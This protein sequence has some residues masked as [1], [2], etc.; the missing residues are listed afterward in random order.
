MNS[1]FGWGG[2]GGVPRRDPLLE[3]DGM[4]DEEGMGSNRPPPFNPS[5]QGAGRY[6]YDEPRAPYRETYQD[7]S[8]QQQ[9]PARLSPRPEARPSPR[10]SPRQQQQVVYPREGPQ[11]IYI[12]RGG[13]QQQPAVVI[14]RDE[15]RSPVA[16]GVCCALMVFI[17]GFTFPLLWLLAC[18][19]LSSPSRSVRFLSRCSILCLIL[20]TTGLGAIILND[21]KTGK[22]PWDKECFFPWD[23]KCKYPPKV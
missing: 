23:P 20:V 2:G 22:W 10:Q 17:L 8:R 12:D 13:G 14:L 11:T 4:Y 19:Q 1:L 3:D 5:V 15:R 6:D 7:Y 9:A 21:A 16:E 18:C